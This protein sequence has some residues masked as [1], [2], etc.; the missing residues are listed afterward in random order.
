MAKLRKKQWAK[1]VQKL[2]FNKPLHFKVGQVLTQDGDYSCSVVIVEVKK[3]G[4]HIRK[5]RRK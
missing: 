5:E 1:E 4:L 3:D 2:D